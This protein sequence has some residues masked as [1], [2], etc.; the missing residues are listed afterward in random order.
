MIEPRRKHRVEGT[1]GL[2][3]GT[4]WFA[5]FFSTESTDQSLKSDKKYLLAALE[6]ALEYSSDQDTKN[7]ALLISGD[8]N[9]QKIIY[10]ANI[11]PGSIKSTPE[12]I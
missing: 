8:Q 9:S 7:G 2:P 1:D 6:Y 3:N 11:I 10:S 4:V 12:R 5:V